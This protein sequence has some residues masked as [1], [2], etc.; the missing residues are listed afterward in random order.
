LT[1]A[2]SAALEALEEAGVH[3]RIE[4][5]P[6]ASYFRQGRRSPIASELPVSAHL[7]QVLHLA[8]PQ[9]SDRHPTWFT[10][11]KAKRRLQADRAHEEG[12]ELVRVVDRAIGRLQR[13]HQETHNL[14]DPL[15]QVQFEAPRLRSPIPAAS[16]FRYLRGSSGGRAEIEIAVNGYTRKISRRGVDRELTRRAEQYQALKFRRG[17]LG[18]GEGAEAPQKVEFIDNPRRTVPR[19]KSSGTGKR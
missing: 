16:F 15:R 18:M 3:G 2:Q 17:L 6:F 12:N 1:P 9:E 10:A 11:E 7:C 14:P 4:D 19:S 8:A 5:V 13:L